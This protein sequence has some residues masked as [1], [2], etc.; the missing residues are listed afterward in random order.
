M[1]EDPAA[2]MDDPQNEIATLVRTLHETQERLQELTGGEVDAVLH[3]G[4]HSYLLHEAQEKMRQSETAQH[5]LAGTQASIL[6]ALPAHIALLDHDGG[7]LS[8]NDGWRRFAE[9]NG[10]QNSAAWPVGLR[11]SLSSIPAIPPPRSAGSSCG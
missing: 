10:L 5:D 6:N 2:M 11:N 1:I 7:I 4:G 3:P 8:V 9:S